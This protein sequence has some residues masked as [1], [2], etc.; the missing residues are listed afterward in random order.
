MAWVLFFAGAALLLYAGVAPR[1]EGARVNARSVA[2]ESEKG[3]VSVA[4]PSRLAQVSQGVLQRFRKR[5]KAS[6]AAPVEDQPAPRRVRR[7]RRSSE[8]IAPA[9][10]QPSVTPAPPVEEPIVVDDA[11]E[12]VEEVAAAAAAAATAAAAVPAVA[13]ATVA[14]TA[15][16]RAIEPPPPPPERALESQVQPAWWTG[17]LGD[18]AAPSTDERVR[19]VSVLGALGEPWCLEALQRALEDEEDARVRNAIQAV[20]EHAPF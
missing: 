20:L 15:G 13:A 18:V 8:A 12:P 14:D 5:V 10:V 17:L 11:I 16:L 4:T 3:K 9:I 2:S 1:K 6:N 7:R 19:V